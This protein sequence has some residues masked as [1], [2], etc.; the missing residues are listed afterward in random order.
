MNNIDLDV[1]SVLSKLQTPKKEITGIATGFKE[2]DE[3]TGGINAGEIMLVSALGSMGKTAFVLSVAKNVAIDNK[4]SVLFFSTENS[5]DTITVR[6]LSLLSQIPLKLFS[7]KHSGDDKFQLIKTAGQKLS[8]APIYIDN[9]S[10]TLTDIVSESKQ[11]ADKLKNT[12]KPVSLIIID[13][14]AILKTSNKKTETAMKELKNLNIPI[15]ATTRWKG[16]KNYKGQTPTYAYLRYLSASERNTDIITFI[17]RNSYFTTDYDFQYSADL[18]TVKNT[19][20]LCKTI[21]LSFERDFGEFKDREPNPKVGIFFILGNGVIDAK[22]QSLKELK[23]NGYS[24]DSDFSHSDVFD[25]AISKLYPQYVDYLE[26]PR[27]RV[28]YL[29]KNKQFVVYLDESKDTPSIRK[30]II[31]VFDLPENTKFEYDE[32]YTTDIK[33]LQ[34]LF[35]KRI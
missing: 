21:P 35:K 32:H 28:V 31:N 18:I 5:K 29:V 6:L 17:H 26:I 10:F 19:R 13:D 8:Q 9:S 7:K 4:K 20:G 16:V 34:K 12:D 3:I 14:S 33:K 15:I 30:G 1:A 11:L 27:G 2:F 24:I 25:D 23:S 22:P